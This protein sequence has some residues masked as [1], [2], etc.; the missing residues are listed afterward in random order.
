MSVDQSVDPLR[1]SAYS[2]HH[3]SKEVAFRIANFT[4]NAPKS[5][6]SEDVQRFTRAAVSDFAPVNEDEAARYI[7]AV[8]WL[9]MWSVE[10]GGLPLDRTVIFSAANRRRF[11]AHGYTSRGAK[12][13]AGVSYLLERIAAYLLTFNPARPGVRV[14]K[15]AEPFAPYSSAEIARFRSQTMTRSTALQRA[16]WRA[17]L[18]LGAGLALSVAEIMLAEVSDVE[19]RGDHLV[20]H[21]GGEERSV[22]C[23]AAWE[24]ELRALLSDPEVDT[25]LYPKRVRPKKPAF[26]AKQFIGIAANP[27]EGF[28]IERLRSTWI[29]AHVNAGTPLVP[30][31]ESLGVKSLS[32]LERLAPF[33]AQPSDEELVTAFRLAGEK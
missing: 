2:N 15:P 19:D 13:K 28:Q 14:P 21:V 24:S 32:T 12:G 26:Q 3:L 8:A 27:G 20:M 6:W 25:F 18:T 23:L 29:V 7:S 4:P 10:P 30:L 11:L 5:L 1:H 31:M 9:T 16:R 17:L 33:Y 22:V